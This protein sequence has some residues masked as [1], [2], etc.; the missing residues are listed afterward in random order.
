MIGLALDKRPEDLPSRIQFR[1]LLEDRMV[2]ATVL[3]HASNGLVH[4]WLREWKGDVTDAAI[5]ASDCPSYRLLIRISYIKSRQ[6][7]AVKYRGRSTP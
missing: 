6:Y 1:P 2:V 7:F 5:V 4:G 3:F